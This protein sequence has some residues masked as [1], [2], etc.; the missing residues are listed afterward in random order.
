MNLFFSSLLAAAILCLFL[1]HSLFQ[2]LGCFDCALHLFL[3]FILHSLLQSFAC[4]QLF[5]HIVLASSYSCLIWTCLAP[6][7]YFTSLL[8][9][10]HTKT[11]YPLIT[12]AF[13]HS[14][15]VSSYC[16]ISLHAIT[17]KAIANG[18]FTIST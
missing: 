9:F 6:G 4:I 11:F 8:C 14:K 1:R 18:I 13:V 5:F 2:Y 10:N 3:I 16:N 17:I 12:L 7:T 15:L